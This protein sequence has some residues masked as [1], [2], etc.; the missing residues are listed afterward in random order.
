M[1]EANGHTGPAHPP[2]GHSSAESTPD[3]LVK[4]TTPEGLEI[5]IPPCRAMEWKGDRRFQ[6]ALH[7]AALECRGGITRR[8]KEK[9]AAS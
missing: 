5:L 2:A 4:V 8:P 6:D 1:S 9:E 7:Y 3:G